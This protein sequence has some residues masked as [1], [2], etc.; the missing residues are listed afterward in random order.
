MTYLFNR[1]V[2]LK[3]RNRDDLKRSDDPIHEYLADLIKDRLAYVLRE[4]SQILIIG[5]LNIDFPKATVFHIPQDI[6]A[7]S[8]FLPFGEATFDL[9]ISYMDLHHA[10]DIPGILRQINYSL[11][12]DGLFLGCFLGGNSLW[13]IRAAA[14][15]AE[16]LVRQGCSPRVAPMISLHDAASL[17]Q[18]AEFAIPV[19][20]HETITITEATGVDLLKRIQHLGLSNSLHNGY[21]GLSGKSFMANLY[22]IL[23]EEHSNTVELDILF[24]SGWAPAPN[25]QK[26]LPRG[27]GQI[28]LGSILN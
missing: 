5:D 15:K 28:F 26:A 3:R 23:E 9:V 18:R 21:K 14:Q 2:Q 11:K 27:S 20:D 8:D 17:L 16:L 4:F 24:L 10:N 1:S 22:S 13:Q 19:L 25:Q 7:T 6:E 12:P